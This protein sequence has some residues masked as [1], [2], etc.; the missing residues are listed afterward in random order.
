MTYLLDN[1]VVSY[2]FNSRCEAD[3]MTAAARC[4]MAIADEVVVEAKR[5]SGD[6]GRF[7]A[8][9]ATGNITSLEILVGSD[10]DLA[11]QSL[12][13][14]N[15]DR[16][17]GERAS[18]A[19][20]AHDPSLVFVA[21]DKNAMWIALAELHSPGERMIGIPVFLRRL[22]EQASLA[23]D[24]IDAVMTTWNGR[25]PTWWAPWRAGLTKPTARGD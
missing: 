19:L 25:R 3:L 21:N 8:W 17:K 9:F 12:K 16:G 24:A 18:I 20:A 1:N 13:S 2:F 23:A 14:S 10:V 22:K 7:K 6:G 15:S 5:N 11:Y 4:P